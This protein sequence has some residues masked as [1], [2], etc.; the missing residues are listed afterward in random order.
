MAHQSKI[1]LYVHIFLFPILTDIHTLWSKTEQKGEFYVKRL[2]IQMDFTQSVRNSEHNTLSVWHSSIYTILLSSLTILVSQCL[3]RERVRIASLYRL[4][5]V[6][7]TCAVVGIR[8][9]NVPYTHRS[10]MVRNSCTSI[11]EFNT[12]RQCTHTKQ[13]HHQ[14]YESVIYHSSCRSLVKL[15]NL[16]T[17]LRNYTTNEQSTSLINEKNFP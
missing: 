14:Y 16:H 10:L 15:V 3:P 2:Q 1:A 6:S 11:R 9:K 17:R 12:I 13:W 5:E 7:Y 4:R 8:T